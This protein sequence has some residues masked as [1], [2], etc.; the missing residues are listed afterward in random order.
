VQYTPYKIAALREAHLMVL[1]RLL[2]RLALDLQRLRSGRHLRRR[3]LN[4]S[5][6]LQQF[7]RRFQKRVVQRQLTATG[8]SPSALVSTRNR[9]RWT[10]RLVVNGWSGE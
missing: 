4:Q 10:F 1:F 8:L 9:E 2:D 6:Q 5:F 3:L 7:R